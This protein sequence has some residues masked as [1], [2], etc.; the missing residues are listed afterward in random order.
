MSTRR[1]R[2]IA[3]ATLAVFGAASVQAEQAQPSS[4]YVA[5]IYFQHITPAVLNPGQWV[6][7]PGTYVISAN[8]LADC[9]DQV[10]GKL[11][12]LGAPAQND[13]DGHYAVMSVH[14]CRYRPAWAVGE[15]NSGISVDFVHDFVEGENVLRERYQINRYEAELD[16]LH[17]RFVPAQ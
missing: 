5:T 17:K 2:L 10:D 6:N 7:T 8:T 4:A 11:D 3:A 13:S 12:W 16:A 1:I 9:Q 15:A 14:P